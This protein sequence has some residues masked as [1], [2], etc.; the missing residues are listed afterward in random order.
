M[1]DDGGLLRL[2]Q[3]YAPLSC[4][5]AQNWHHLRYFG[6]SPRSGPCCSGLSKCFF[7]EYLGCWVTSSVCFHM[8]GTIMDFSNSSLR[9]PVQPHKMSWDGTWRSVPVIL[10]HMCKMGPLL[11]WC[12]VNIWSLASADFTLQILLEH[13]WASVWEVNTQKTEGAVTN[14]KSPGVM[15]S[16]KTW[17]VPELLWTRCKPS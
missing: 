10:P 16:G 7:T 1:A 17:I 15:W 11:W 3:S 5:C 9:L 14:V 12:N 4:S 2:G 6:H 13:L 8:E